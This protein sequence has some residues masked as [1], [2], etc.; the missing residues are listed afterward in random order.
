MALFPE[1]K[2]PRKIF[3]IVREDEAVSIILKLVGEVCNL[4]CLYCYEKRKPYAGSRYLS[5]TVVAALLATLP[6]NKV[7]LELHGGEPLLYGKDRFLELAAALSASGKQIVRVTMQTNGTL[8]DKDHLIFLRSTFPALQLGISCDG[9]DDLSASRVD[10][11][12]SASVANVERA[13]RVCAELQQ[14]VG[15]I[16]VVT[17][18]SLGRAEK[19]LTYLS[20]FGCIRAVKLVPCFD[21]AV[22]QH[23]G[24]KRRKE[25]VEILR[26]SGG[27]YPPWAI[28]PLEYQSF[29]SEAWNW[30][31]SRRTPPFL[32]EPFLSVLKRLSGHRPNNCHF[33]DRKC[34]HVL[35]LY[36]DGTVGACDELGK[37]EH[38]YG[39][40]TQG[41]ATRSSVHWLGEVQEG[42]VRQ[43]LAKCEACSVADTCGGGCIATRLRFSALEE[44][45][46]CE[47]RV[48]LVKMVR[49]T[50]H[51]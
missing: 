31:V 8:L 17:Q 46:Y 42:Q 21:Y 29:L 18:Q 36:P 11:A 3:S 12:G 38:E 43:L 16:S 9:P 19:L 24:P 4:D 41:A 47:H 25:T 14:S 49:G 32:L 2:V 5:P 22:N 23:A 6:Q 37:R 33:S 44:A 48:A 7:A 45:R 34:S 10:L 35:T 13:L 20:Q 40:V 28:S 30:W 15:V 39:R 27:Q 50:L 1:A 26:R 51:D